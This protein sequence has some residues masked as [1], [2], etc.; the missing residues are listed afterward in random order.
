GELVNPG[1]P[2]YKVG[3]AGD[4]GD[5]IIRFGLSDRDI[6]KLKTGDTGKV[7][8]DGLPDA[9][10]EISISE[11]SETS[12]PQTGLFEV[13]ASFNE[14]VPNLKNGFIGKVQITPSQ[15]SEGLKVPLNA[16]VEGSQRRAIIFYTTNQQTAQRLEVDVLDIRKDYF[17]IATDALPA[18]AN[19]I[20]KG[21]AYLRDQDS[22][23]VNAST[24][25]NKAEEGK[26]AKQNTAK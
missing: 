12:N 22:I 9:S 25:R 6:I 19:I 5:K 10:F 21:A 17:L 13:E 16:L 1:Q 11:I 15:G 2:V 20:V 23:I 18:N 24:R 14:E 4:T 8:F 26:K 3:S 7:T